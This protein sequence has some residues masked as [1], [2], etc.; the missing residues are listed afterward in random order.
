MLRRVIN[1]VVFYQSFVVVSVTQSGMSQHCVSGKVSADDQCV[2]YSIFT[3]ST[4]V[5]TL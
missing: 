5:L 1:K 4:L 3:F 2:F